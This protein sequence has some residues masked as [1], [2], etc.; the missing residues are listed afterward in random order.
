MALGSMKLEGSYMPFWGD[1]KSMMRGYLEGRAGAVEGV[2][3]RVERRA[4]EGAMGAREC[5]QTT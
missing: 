5:I 4:T 1:W 2:K 3:E